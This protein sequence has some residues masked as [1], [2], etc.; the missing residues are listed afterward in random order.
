MMRGTLGRTSLSFLGIICILGIYIG[1]VVW[2]RPTNLF[3]YTNDDMMYFSSAKALAEGRGYILPSL[4]GAPPATKY[5]VLLPWI[6]SFGWRWAPAFP[7]N[8]ATGIAVV[9]VFGC[10]FLVSGFFLLRRCLCLSTGAALGII[11]FCALQP[12][13]LLYSS[14]ILSDV[15]FAAL[16]VVAMVVS[17]RGLEVGSGVTRAGLSGLVSGSSILMRVTGIPFAAGLFLFAVW[18]RAWGQAAIFAVAVGPFAVGVLWRALIAVPPVPASAVSSPGPGWKQTWL[19]YTNYA[20]FRRMASPDLHTAW[21]FFLNQLLYLASEIPGYF[22]SPLSR[23]NVAFWFA[24]TILVLGMVVA[25]IV[26]QKKEF[27]FRPFHFALAATVLTVLSWDYPDATRFMIPFLPIFA[28]ALWVEGKRAL[29]ACRNDVRMSRPAERVLSTAGLAITAGLGLC[30]GL[31]FFANSDRTNLRQKSLERARVLV[32]KR[33]AYAWLRHNAGPRD[34]VIA[35]E[36]GCLYLYTGRK[37]IAPIALLPNGEYDPGR[38]QFDLDHLTDVARAVGATYWLASP[39]DSDKQWRAS[40]P[41]LAQRLLDI[42]S[43]LPEVFRS[44]GGGV[45]IYSLSCLRAP[46]RPSCRE[47]DSV[48]FPTASAP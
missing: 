14:S 27:G 2:V 38:F 30:V 7:K 42:E 5:P 3:G 28:A 19:Y 43:A 31:N 21:T 16:A 35:S 29:A 18:K 25:G 23:K 8:I 44:P 33:E 40:K 12:A 9:V 26:R 32:E 46:R 41:L 45:M 22:L 47:A 17:D 10:L 6:L 15:P 1:A 20:A 4:P 34:R 11:G 24:S 37:A 39:D 36:D 48:P 13:F